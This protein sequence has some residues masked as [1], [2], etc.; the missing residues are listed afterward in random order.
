MTFARRPARRQTALLGDRETE[1]D[2]GRLLVVE[3]QRWEPRARS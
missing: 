2:G 1:H 3:H